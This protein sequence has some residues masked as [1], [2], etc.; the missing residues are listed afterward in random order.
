MELLIYALIFFIIVQN[1]FIINFTFKSLKQNKKIMANL[2]EL[3][4]AIAAL[5]VTVDAEQAQIA[6]LLATNAGVITGLNDQI[7][8]LTQQL[9]DGITPEQVQASID[10]LNAIKADVEATV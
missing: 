5:Q 2:T 10:A 1:Q 8:I 6:E 9:A 4:D 7:A 3:N